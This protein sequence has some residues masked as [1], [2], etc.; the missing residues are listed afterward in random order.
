MPAENLR[1]GALEALKNSPKA[2]IKYSPDWL[3]KR[4]VNEKRI[5]N[6]FLK[7]ILSLLFDYLTDVLC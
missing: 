6:P 2:K 3:E 4:E 1:W 5:S 7:K